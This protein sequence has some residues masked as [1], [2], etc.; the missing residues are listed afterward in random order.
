MKPKERLER[1]PY[2]LMDCHYV[3]HTQSAPPAARQAEKTEQ[4]HETPHAKECLCPLCWALKWKEGH[5]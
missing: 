1:A 5:S 2:F 3:A 4:E